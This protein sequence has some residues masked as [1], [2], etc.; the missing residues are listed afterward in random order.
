MTLR[1]LILMLFVGLAQPLAAQQVRVLSGEHEGF[2][3]LV[4]LLPKDTGWSLRETPEARVLE[5]QNPNLRFRLN[6][7]FTYIPKSRI[8]QVEQIPGS[9]NVRI[10]VAPT[11]TVSTFELQSGAVVVDVLDGP[12]TDQSGPVANTPMSRSYRSSFRSDGDMLSLLWKDYLPNS[13]SGSSDQVTDP[14]Q[15]LEPL[16][17]R[18]GQ[19][20]AD[21][22]EQ[23]GR[24]AAQ[25]LIRI[26][27]PALPTFDLPVNSEEPSSGFPAAEAQTPSL[28]T[29]HLALR[30]E[31]SIDRDARLLNTDGRVSDRGLKCAADREF[32]LGAWRGD[33]PAAELIGRGRRDLL[34]EFDVPRRD[35]VVDLSRSYL[36]IGFGAEALAL[37]N[38]YPTDDPEADSL[39]MIA[40]ILDGRPV[41]PISPFLQMTDCDSK[42]AL[43]AL[44]GS[45]PPPP[46]A[47]VR[48]G[49][50]QRAFA[51]L[52]AEVRAITGQP[53]VDKLIAI[54]ASDIAATIRATLARAPGDH[55]DTVALIDAKL[56]REAGDDATAEQHLEGLVSRNSEDAATAIINLVASRLDS[57]RPVDDDTIEQA[58]AL[59][60]ELGA[61]EKGLSLLRAN[62]LGLG[63][64]GRFEKA[65]SAMQSWDQDSSPDARQETLAKLFSQVAHVPDDA[66]LL[67]TFFA[68]RELSRSIDLPRDT[69]LMLSARLVNLGFSSAAREVLGQDGRLYD[70]GRLL[71]AKA[72]LAERDAP[73]AL[74]Y[75][76]AQ[77]G[78]EASR[79]RGEALKLL[80]EHAAAL[81]E[82]DRSQSTDLARDAAW[83]SGD[84]QR[85]LEDGSDQQKALL[86][87]F[88]IGQGDEE[89][90]D[91]ADGPAQS[92][93]PISKANKLI[94]QSEAERKALSDLLS[95][96]PLPPPPEP[97]AASGGS[98]GL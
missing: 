56:A 77:S 42:V 73:A 72:A 7:V 15:G 39:Y 41:D 20:E 63:S 27:T 45:Q 60:F 25:G 24:A 13:P 26:D 76:S 97:P 8:T 6:S 18:V 2:S 14:S 38:T 92:D 11:T 28:P 89:S 64:V 10:S 47:K 46:S 55:A 68:H 87:T 65:F 1:A 16:G 88:G 84:W 21:L 81:D 43:W 80:G 37:L 94:S 33:G 70:A 98:T 35:A 49:A 75:L 61:S 40:R 96:Y 90:S 62:I 53:L 17:G 86:T 95:Q 69:R 22:L 4:F 59:A 67:K 91:L 71:L 44:L 58:A 57:G 30:A 54:G 83:R 51:A 31:T 34:G 23:I 50:V 66:L 82:F 5:V 79:I 9:A 52:P 19:A 48:L 78:E 32:D 93:G 74:A 12:A 36:S 3:R 85:V 29:D